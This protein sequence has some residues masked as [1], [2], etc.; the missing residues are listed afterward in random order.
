MIKV[1]QTSK[2]KT[3]FDVRV[4][5]SG[6]RVSRTVSTTLTEAKR[7]ESK[8]LHDLINGKFEILKKTNDPLFKQ[9]AK[10]YEDSVLWQ[11]SWRRT[12][13]HIEQLNKFFR[14]KRLSSITAQD[15]INYRTFRLQTVSPTT[16]NRE[17]SCLL[18]MLN[19][20]IN[21]DNFRINKNPLKN[22]R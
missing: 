15:F 16:A 7:V 8:L 9:Y 3:V 11:K 13:Q 17:R 1:R 6:V 10:D 5:Y 4:Q 2:G 12:K 19:L 22:I 20:A 14:Q 18:R 21:S